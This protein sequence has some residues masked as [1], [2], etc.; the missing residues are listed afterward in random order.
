MLTWWV[1]RYRCYRC[2]HHADMVGTPGSVS[3]VQSHP[4]PHGYTT[5]CMPHYV[6]CPRYP[7]GNSPFAHDK[8]IRRFQV[9]MYHLV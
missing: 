2:L 4:H 9:A 6:L 5:N 1:H 3:M 7:S 8:N